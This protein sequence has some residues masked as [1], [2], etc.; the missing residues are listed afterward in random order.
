M[1]KE[2]VVTINGH[3]LSVGEAM[4]LRVA[5]TTFETFCGNDEFGKQLAAG[6]DT[7][8]RTLLGLLCSQSDARAE[9]GK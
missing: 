7:H 6:Y 1:D 4:T 5:V 2:A 3:T 9:Q 8:K